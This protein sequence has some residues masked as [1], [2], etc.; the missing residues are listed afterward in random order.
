MVNVNKKLT[1]KCMY[2]L[3]FFLIPLRDIALH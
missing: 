3:T 2:S 1:T